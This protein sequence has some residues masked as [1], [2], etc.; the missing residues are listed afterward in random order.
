MTSQKLNLPSVS[1]N[2]VDGNSLIT[3]LGILVDKNIRFRR[4]RRRITLTAL[5]KHSTQ[6]S[7]VTIDVMVT[8][9]TFLDDIK[10]LCPSP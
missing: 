6:M 2:R 5:L 7:A 10:L 3:T 4:A 8:R 1:I 9:V